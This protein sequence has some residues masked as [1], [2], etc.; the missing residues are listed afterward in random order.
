MDMPG[1]HIYIYTDIL[2]LYL[3][4]TMA[5]DHGLC[6]KKGV[7]ESNG[8][9]ARAASAGPCCICQRDSL[10]ACKLMKHDDPGAHGMNRDQSTMNGGKL[11]R[12]AV[13][14]AKVTRQAHSL[15]N[16]A[17]AGTQPADSPP[18]SGL[19]THN[20]QQLAGLAAKQWPQT[21]LAC[22]SPCSAGRWGECSGAGSQEG[23][24]RP[25]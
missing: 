10:A 18:G 13:G 21:K 24:C 11:L 22:L 12:R 5:Q 25:T 16:Q 14:M 3:H 6:R 9:G 15:Q 4:Y 2:T 1:A 17:A 8:T 23:G 19:K 20:S 7:R